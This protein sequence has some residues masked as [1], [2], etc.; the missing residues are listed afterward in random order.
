LEIGPS[1]CMSHSCIW[2]Y[3]MYLCMH[4]CVYIYIYIYIYV[5]IY[6]CI[7]IHRYPVC[8]CWLLL[9]RA[10]SRA[11]NVCSSSVLINLCFYALQYCKLPSVCVC[12][13]VYVCVCVRACVCAHVFC[14]DAS[15]DLEECLRCLCMRMCV[16]L[17]VCLFVRLFVWVFVCFYSP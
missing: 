1:V 8:F 5:Y 3:Y 16:C 13:C 6:I 4:V 10:G 7:Y 9:S 11:L 12:V 14:C 15:Q 17:F 2:V